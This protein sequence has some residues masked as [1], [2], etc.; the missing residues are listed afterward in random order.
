MASLACARYEAGK[1]LNDPSGRGRLWH[2]IWHLMYMLA[3]R[4]GRLLHK[5]YLQ[6]FAL[7]YFISSSSTIEETEK[8]NFNYSLTNH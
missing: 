6:N 4:R 1:A 5:W 8:Q 2:R 7:I 3:R